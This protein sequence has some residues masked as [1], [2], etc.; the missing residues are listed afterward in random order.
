MSDKPSFTKANSRT[1]DKFNVR[2]PDGMRDAIAKKANDEHKAMNTWIVNGLAKLLT[3]DDSHGW[4]P[5]GYQMV[6]HK[7]TDKIYVISDVHFEGDV[8]KLVLRRDSKDEPWFVDIDEVKPLVI[9]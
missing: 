5:Q 1:A 3:E 2:L 4:I 9:R 6:V 7:A 8:P